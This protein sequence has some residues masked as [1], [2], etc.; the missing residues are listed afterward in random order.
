MDLQICSNT[1]SYISST[2]VKKKR[3]SLRAA[4]LLCSCS[5]MHPFRIN[6]ELDFAVSTSLPPNLLLLLS[7][8]NLGPQS[9][10]KQHQGV[11]GSICCGLFQCLPVSHILCLLY[12]MLS[13]QLPHA[14]PFQDTFSTPG[15]ALIC[16]WVGAEREHSGYHKAQRKAQKYM[17]CNHGKGPEVTA[18]IILYCALPNDSKCKARRNRAVSLSTCPTSGF[19]DHLK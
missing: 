8:R 18:Y 5:H 6:T 15:A 7:K 2:L 4:D 14:I 12:L 19:C 1:Q 16:A 10:S 9:P 17:L 3:G 11:S 13:H